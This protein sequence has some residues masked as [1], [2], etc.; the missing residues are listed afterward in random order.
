M[1]YP[2]VPEQHQALLDEWE[3]ILRDEPDP[4]HTCIY[5]G[6]PIATRG[7][8][9]FRRLYCSARHQRAASRE[10]RAEGPSDW[11]PT[12]TPDA[13]LDNADADGAGYIDAFPG[14]HPPLNAPVVP[15]ESEPNSEFGW[16]WEIIGSDRAYR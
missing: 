12:Y 1:N 15:R 11:M 16:A 7:T 10:R 8:R 6:G 4:N 13:L 5:C 14:D 3:A 9:G 2:H